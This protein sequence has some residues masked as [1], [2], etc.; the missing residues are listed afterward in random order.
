[1]NEI[2]KSIDGYE[3]YDVSNFGRIRSKQQIFNHYCGCKRIMPSKIMK[4]HICERGYYRIGLTNNG[5]QR[6]VFVH[7]LVAAAFISNPENKPY[8]NHKDCNRLNNNVNNLEWCTQSEN[9]RYAYALGRC[10]D[11]L[12]RQRKAVVGINKKTRQSICFK[13]MADAGRFFNTGHSAIGRC[14]QG[15]GKSAYGY[16]WKYAE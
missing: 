10:E 9:V 4:P 5:K 13:S 16:Y 3:N 1:M 14:C 8:I 7:R 6:L 15:L 11:A 12:D 2:W